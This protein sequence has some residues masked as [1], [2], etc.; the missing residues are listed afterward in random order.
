MI[1]LTNNWAST[2]QFVR[3]SRDARLLW[4]DCLTYCTAQKTNGQ[5]P[6][7]AM[8]L[9]GVGMSKKRTWQCIGEL[10]HAQL[11]EFVAGAACYCMLEAG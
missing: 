5:I 2:L 8:P 7:E 9:I 4:L 3:L 1:K 10:E 6:I 11:L